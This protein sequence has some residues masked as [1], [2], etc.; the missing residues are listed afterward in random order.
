MNRWWPRKRTS[1][2][3]HCWPDPATTRF[4]LICSWTTPATSRCTPRSSSTSVHT[5]RRCL[6]YGGRTIPSFSL[7]AP[8][9][10][11]ATTRAPKCT[12][13]TLVISRSRHTE[14]KSRRS[15]A[16]SSPPRASHNQTEGGF[17][18]D[19]REDQRKGEQHLRG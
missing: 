16:T 4:S 13:S 14:L 1:L 18:D 3:R 17:Y 10:S 9:P 5:S 7:P 2:T 19:G 8:T 6:R 12:S 11:S 15:S